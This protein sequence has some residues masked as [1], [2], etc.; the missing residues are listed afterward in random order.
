MLSVAILNPDKLD[1]LLRLNLMLKLSR[2]NLKLKF[3]TFNAEH[4]LALY[5]KRLKNKKI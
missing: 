2:R 1:A 4:S 5:L 3:L